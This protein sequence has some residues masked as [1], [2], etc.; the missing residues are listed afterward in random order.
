M[1]HIWYMPRN[2]FFRSV[3]AGS[4]GRFLLTGTLLSVALALLLSVLLFFSCH[5]TA[6]LLLHEPECAESLR[7]LSVSGGD[8]IP[9]PPQNENQKMLRCRP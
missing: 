5:L 2:S 6:D 3:Y 7:L 1:R 9:S 8:I 4:A